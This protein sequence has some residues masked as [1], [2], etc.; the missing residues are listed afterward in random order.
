[1]KILS[2]DKANIIIRAMLSQPDRKWVARDF[3]KEFGVGRARGKKLYQN[4]A[5]RGLSEGFG[6]AGS[7]IAY[8]KIKKNFLRNGLKSISLSL[9]KPIFITQPERIFFPG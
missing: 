1:M 7:R 2:G 6:L 5:P 9:T 4:C 3:E 8:C